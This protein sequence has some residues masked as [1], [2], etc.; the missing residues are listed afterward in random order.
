MTEP[1]TPEAVDPS[2]VF[3]Q[4]NALAIVAALNDEASD[5]GMAM[6][7]HLIAQSPPS[8]DLALALAELAHHFLIIL[9]IQVG[10]DTETIL[11]DT[12]MAQS[13]ASG[14]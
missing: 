4:L 9:A 6:A 13:K 5:R 10:I 2:A 11:S 12:A 7:R 14:R 1:A 3:A 8:A